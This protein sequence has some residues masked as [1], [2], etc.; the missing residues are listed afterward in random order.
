MMP[1]AAKRCLQQAVDVND[2]HSGPYPGIMVLDRT[3]SMGVRWALN[4]MYDRR[5]AVGS[6]LYTFIPTSSVVPL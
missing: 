3:S 6:L 5:S 4:A 1:L 2:D